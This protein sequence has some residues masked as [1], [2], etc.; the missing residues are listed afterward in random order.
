MALKLNDLLKAVVEEEGSD[1][2]MKADSPPVIRIDD[3]LK[4]IGSDVPNYADLEKL[5]QFLMNDYQKKL[6]QTHPEIDLVYSVPS[7]G[8]FRVN[9]YRQRGTV[10]F[11]FRRVNLKIPSLDELCLPPVIKDI[12]LEPRGLILVTGATGSGKSTTLAAMVDY[13][14]TN[15][16]GHIITIE[17]PVEFLHKDKKSIVSQREVGIDTRSYSEALRY[18]LRQAPDVILLGE[19]RD[20]ETVT[21]AIFFAETGHLVLSTLHSTNTNQTLERIL[22]FFP[23]DSHDEIY[24]Q[25]SMNL[26]AI[27]S[28]RLL[29]RADGSGRVPA[30]EVLITT[31]RIKDLIRRGETDKIKSTIEGSSGEGMQTFD[32]HLYELYKAGLITLED[33]LLNA[34]SRSDLRLKLKGFSTGAKIV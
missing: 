1:L 32:Q 11:V 19:M 17:D 25:L 28:Q 3:K 27:F 8:R 31:P 5:A 9:I 23:V 7:V 14:N 20:V 29:P 16:E 12:V 21:S 2:Y 30:V 6:F 22:Q 13:R 18:A 26:K 34:D 24:F 33:T 15:I 4:R 10:G